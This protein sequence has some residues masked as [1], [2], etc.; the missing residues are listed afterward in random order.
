MN[1]TFIDWTFLVI[2]NRMSVCLSSFPISLNTSN[3]CY[4]LFVYIKI[5]CSK[6]D[7]KF[8]FHPLKLHVPSCLSV[9]MFQQVRWW[10]RVVVPDLAFALPWWCRVEAWVCWL[11]FREGLFPSSDHGVFRPYRHHLPLPN[12]PRPPRRFAIRRRGRQ[13]S[14]LD[15]DTKMNV[16]SCSWSSTSNHP[17]YFIRLLSYWL[18]NE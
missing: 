15:S 2:K 18:Y 1:S 11:S 5:T 7:I 14:L 16:S 13:H 6:C 17:K 9:Y 8:M 4:C 3:I 10:W 12:L